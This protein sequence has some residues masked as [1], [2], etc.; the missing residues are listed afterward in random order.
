MQHVSTS[1]LLLYRDSS[2][3]GALPPL[4]EFPELFLVLFDHLSQTVNVLISLLQEVDQS[5]VLL[6]VDELTISLF[7]F[8]LEDR[9]RVITSRYNTTQ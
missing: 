4:L 1:T 9:G 5:L 3:L 6:L 7:I 2:L 8:S